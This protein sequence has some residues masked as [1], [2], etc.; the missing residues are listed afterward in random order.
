MTAKD[1]APEQVFK[2]LTQDQIDQRQI[3]HLT[4]FA[5]GSTHSNITN[6][7]DRPWNTVTIHTDGECYTCIC[8]AW[9]PISVGNIE[10]FSSLD[11]IWNNPT[12]EFLQQTVT[13]KKYTYCAV[14]HCGIPDHELYQDPNSP[15]T[16][17]INVSVDESCNLA[18]PSCRREAVNITSGPVFDKKLKMVEHLTRLITEFNKPLEIIMISSGDPLASL[19]M[20]PLVLNWV[21]Q[22]N[23]KI[24][25]FTNG[26]LMKKLL[27]TSSILQ[28]I[29]KFWISVDAGSEDVYENVRRPG[30]YSVLRENLDWLTENKPKD[31]TVVLKFTLSAG[32]ALDIMNF[33]KMC[34]HYGFHGDITNLDDQRTW[35]NFNDH[36]VIRNSDHPLHSA[37]VEQLKQASVLPYI[38]VSPFF[39]KVLHDSR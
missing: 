19:I 29:S 22:P 5:R 25:L 3:N 28:D 26:L 35:D 27:P 2:I 13:D 39:N 36:E 32:N 24:T 15:T 6:H 30:K 23:Q 4:S 38:E 11:D 20:R 16:Y 9:L 34:E 10:S 12:A 31:A 33:C 37:A 18:C 17:I 14:N 7:C 8:A 1:Q 21:P